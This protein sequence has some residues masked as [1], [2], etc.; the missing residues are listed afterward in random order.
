MG[1]YADFK[2]NGVSLYSLK[3]EGSALPFLMEAFSPEELIDVEGTSEDDN[4]YYGYRTSAAA[5]KERLE[6]LGY[7]FEKSHKEVLDCCRQ[8]CGMFEN[9]SEGLDDEN[10]SILL[11]DGAGNGVEEFEFYKALSDKSAL[12]EGLAQVFADPADTMKTWWP[13]CTQEGVVLSPVNEVAKRVLEAGKDGVLNFVSSDSYPEPMCVL[14]L[15]LESVSPEV[16]VEYDCTLP[17]RLWDSCIK[18]ELTGFLEQTAFSPSAQ[19]ILITEGGTDD[20]YISESLR[21]L[22]PN[23]CHMFKFFDYHNDANPERNCNAVARLCRAMVSL[24]LQ[25]KIIFLFDNDAAGVESLKKVPPKLPQNIAAIHLPDLDFAKSYPSI[26]PDGRSRS[27]I[28]GRAVTIEFFLGRNALSSEDGA[29]CPIEWV[30]R[31]GSVYQ[32]NLVGDGKKNAQKIFEAELKA[33]AES[34]RRS[35][36][37]DWSS[38]ELLVDY[39]VRVASEL[40]SP[41]SNCER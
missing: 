7:S 10:L 13:E 23:L 34:G 9:L 21:L 33:C 12:I 36:G 14:R 32:G 24:R 25:E 4:G 20:K 16:S 11:L 29:L 31:Q 39:L 19:F 27:D 1:E 6:V 2:I 28:N 22:R 40:R 26:G 38:M 41:G 17:V 35:K 3:N 18:E 37:Y 30:G 15:I 8:G 5:A